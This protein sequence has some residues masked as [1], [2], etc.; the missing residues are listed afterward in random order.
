[1]KE[2][3]KTAVELKELMNKIVKSLKPSAENSVRFSEGDSFVTTSRWVGLE[4]VITKIVPIGNK[5]KDLNIDYE[6]FK[7][8]SYDRNTGRTDCTITI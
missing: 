8:T 2:L 3:N 4:E 5:F 6:V 1:M 7:W